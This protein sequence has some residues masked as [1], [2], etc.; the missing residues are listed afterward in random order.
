MNFVFFF[1]DTLRAESFSSYGFPLETTPNI[2]KF[3]Q[4]AVRFEQAHALHTQCS[5]SRVTMLTGRYMH[6]VGHRTQTHLIQ[7]YEFNY[8]RALKE[9][10][11]HVQYHGKNDAFSA[12]A[13]NLSTSEWWLECGVEKGGLAFPFGEGGYWSMLSTAADC[14]PDDLKNGDYAGVAHAVQWMKE[15]QETSPQKPFLLFIAGKGAHPEYGAPK[16]FHD[17]WPVELVKRKVSL[18]PPYIAGKPKYHS[19]TEGIPHYRN[20]TALSED[21]FY[22][23]HAV[24]LGMISYTDWI[25]GKLL[26]G[27]KEA[28]LEDNTAVFISS[29]HGDFAGDFHMVEKWPGGADDVLTR[30][31][32]YGRVP[33]AAAAARGFV[34]RAP[35]N[36]FDVPRTICDL[37]GLDITSD[38]YDTH[39]GVSLVP[40]LLEGK[41][42]DLSRIVYSEG[43]FNFHREVFPGGSDHQPVPM[44]PRGM[45]Y[46]RAM[47]EMS[48][49][50]KGSPKWVMM[51]NLTHKLVYRPLG[52]SELY[53]MVK[54]PRELSNRWLDEGHQAVR[55]DLMKKLTEWMVLTGDVTPKHRDSR[56]TP[57][58]PYPASTCA[59]S[60]AL[61][62]D[63]SADPATLDLM[64]N[65]NTAGVYQQDLAYKSEPP[66]A[67]PTGSEVEHFV[68]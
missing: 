32:L 68:L 60:G 33:G 47:E 52:E 59:Q 20:L 19:N 3:A 49:G 41:E 37:A 64:P 50:G 9:S 15:W 22:R 12:D 34:S 48:D 30:V 23:I 27:L 14:E 17:R 51:R 58:Y 26:E 38:D 29:D 13:M 46:P 63:L 11:Y 8:F 16:V 53:D 25:F 56:N 42:G 36:L 62:P 66:S 4:T 7:P 43:G 2:D 40:Q 35:V 31:P 45:Y 54:D 57:K 6:V 24:Y 5:P 67:K 1:P 55:Y 44:D 61:G 39:F 65:D 18:R 28:G 21:D 10:G